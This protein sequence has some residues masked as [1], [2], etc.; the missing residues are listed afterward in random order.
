LPIA[1][2]KSTNNASQITGIKNP[3]IKNGSV[4]AAI[5][6]VEVLIVGGGGGGGKSFHGSGA[7]GGGGQVIT[8]TG[9]TV[10]SDVTVTVGAGGNGGDGY[11][12]YF[13]TQL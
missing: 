12:S 4:N 3:T 5:M 8:Q 6:N 13:F 1:G 11:I 2:R 10:S 9:L 7:G